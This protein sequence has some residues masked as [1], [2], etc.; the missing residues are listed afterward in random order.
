MDEPS[1]ER[2][3]PIVGATTSSLSCATI[4]PLGSIPTSERLL[5][6]CVKVQNHATCAAGL[7]RVIGCAIGCGSAALPALGA[8]LGDGPSARGPSTAQEARKSMRKHAVKTIRLTNCLTTT[9][10]LGS[11]ALRDPDHV[12]LAVLPPH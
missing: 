4:A 5:F 1:A 12:A 2:Q 10:G 8:A 6:G 7:V 9:A 3:K 11:D